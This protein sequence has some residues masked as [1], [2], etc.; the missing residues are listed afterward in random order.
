MKQI[1]RRAVV[2]HRMVESPV[3]A[4]SQSITEELEKT[5]DSVTV[6]KAPVRSEIVF[7]YNFQIPCGGRG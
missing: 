4:Q 7:D 6:K 2:V 1:K 5:G 3:V